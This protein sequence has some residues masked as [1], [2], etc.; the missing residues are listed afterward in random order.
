MTHHALYPR[1]MS[2]RPGNC[3][4]DRVSVK[5]NQYPTVA[6]SRRQGGKKEKQRKRTQQ[7][8]RPLWTQDGWTIEEDTEKKLKGQAFNPGA[9]DL[10]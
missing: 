1:V 3:S 4:H 10:C 5:E 6:Q 2:W 7:E 8:E 9:Q